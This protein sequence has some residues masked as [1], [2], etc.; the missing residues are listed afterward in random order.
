VKRTPLLL[1]AS[2]LLVAGCTAQS[3]AADGTA[4]HSSGTSAAG[5]SSA[6]GTSAGGTRSGSSSARPGLSGDGVVSRSAFTSAG[7]TWPLTVSQ[8]TLFC[9]SGTQII[10][11][12]GNGSAYGVNDAA[13]GAG[14]WDDIDA[15]RATIGGHPADLGDL[16]AAGQQ[17][18]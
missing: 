13:R 4:S 16:A 15:I 10:F 5:G 14:E 18:C 12:T 1:A 6:Q 11:T 8:G 9:E 17:L 3:P 7:R 2:A